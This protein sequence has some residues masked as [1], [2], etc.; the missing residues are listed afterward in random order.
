MSIA[1]N[2]TGSI[3]RL[4]L[5]AAQTGNAVT[6]EMARDLIAAL[7]RYG[8]DPEFRVI[9]LTA[10]APTSAW[11]GTPAA[12]L[13]RRA[14][15]TRCA[16]AR[17]PAC[18]RSTELSRALPYRSSPACGGRPGAWARRSLPAPISH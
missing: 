4:N 6:V 10:P 12:D 8:H 11:V 16:T 18:S 1:V 9:A 2:A 3:V 5:N 14:Q 13:R 17:S 15:R 7:D